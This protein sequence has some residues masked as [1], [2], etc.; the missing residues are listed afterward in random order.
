MVS[1]TFQLYL[2]YLGMFANNFFVFKRPSKKPFFI[3]L[4]L[5][6]FMWKE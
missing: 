4:A 5:P 3:D 1:M 2:I 6:E